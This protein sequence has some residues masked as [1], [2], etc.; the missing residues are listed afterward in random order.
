M[1]RELSIAVFASVIC[2]GS[3]ALA[4]LP[5]HADDP[6]SESIDPGG[7]HLAEQPQL[8]PDPEGKAEELRLHG[9]CD[10]AI[11]ILRR[12]AAN[13]RDDIAQYNL[14]QCLLD[15]GKTAADAQHAAQLHEGARWVIRTANMGL[16]NA[17]LSLV[18]V[19]LDGSGVTADPVEAGKW[20]LL[21]HGNGTRLAIGMPDV[22]DDLR[23][24]L[25]SA[26][27]DKA[28]VEAESRANAW[29]PDADVVN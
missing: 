23:A 29:S 1:K 8:P 14:G 10:E 6:T 20:A 15:A 13:D 3:Q 9:K 18:T 27:T 16:P 28:W 21:Y 5:H 24:R 26:L 7:D 4:Q 19:Y 17:Q 2:F 22:S 11:P 25:D 12:L